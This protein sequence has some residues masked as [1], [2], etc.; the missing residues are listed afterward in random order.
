MGD[1]GARL[2][3]KA[4]QVNTSLRTLSIDRNN[5]SVHGYGDIAYAL[6]W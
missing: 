2:M 3:S 1:S 5:I 6:E 4:L